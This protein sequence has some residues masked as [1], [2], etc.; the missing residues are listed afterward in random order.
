MISSSR[1]WSS[2]VPHRSEPRR[3]NPL[4]DLQQV[5]LAGEY[6][7]RHE[8]ERCV[9]YAPPRFQRLPNDD[10]SGSPLSALLAAVGPVHHRSP[11]ETRQR[12]LGR[13]SRYH[14]VVIVVHISSAAP[15]K[16]PTTRPQTTLRPLQSS[17]PENSPSAPP[18][19]EQKETGVRAGRQ[20]DLTRGSPRI[21]GAVK[22]DEDHDER[23]YPTTERIPSVNH[24][25]LR[26]ERE[27]R[28]WES[29]PSERSCQ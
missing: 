4:R 13:G 11:L 21:P 6:V 8:P 18:P 1:K 10:A 3:I 25:T 9:P 16:P 5:L 29:G 28:P 20:A 12:R 23:H 19:W 26:N 24:R 17:P 2:I 27:A 14:V 7:V 15:S 22:R